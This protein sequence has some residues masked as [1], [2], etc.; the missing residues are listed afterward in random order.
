M[1]EMSWEVD[2]E[3][4]RDKNGEADGMNLEVDSKEEVMHIWKSDLWFSRRRWLAGER[5]WQQMKSG[6]CEEVEER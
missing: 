3:V 1:T 6:Y 5:E 4:Y 2:D